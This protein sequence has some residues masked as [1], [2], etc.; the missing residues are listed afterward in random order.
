MPFSVRDLLAR[1]NSAFVYT[2]SP[3]TTLA[4][5]CRLLRERRVGSLV[6][7]EDGACEGLLSDREVVRAVAA[8]RDPTRTPVREVM[9]AEVPAIG[10]E[11]SLDDAAVLLRRGRLRHLLVTGP[12][13]LLGVVSQGDLARFY[14]LRDRASAE[15]AAAQ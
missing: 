5:A 10:L 6:V 12:R 9:A 15:A 2:C 11:T 14:A 7:V 1:K 4:E 13:G 8:G 3:A